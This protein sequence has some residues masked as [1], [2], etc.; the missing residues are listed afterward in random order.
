MIN[1]FVTNISIEKQGFE[2]VNQFNTIEPKI[3]KDEFLKQA[4]TKII[5]NK[6][7]PEDV[8]TAEFEAVKTVYSTYMVVDAHYTGNFSASIG[9]ERV[10]E[11][12]TTEEYYDSKLGMK[13]YRP[14]TKTRTV[15]DWQPF[16]GVI[17]RDQK[18][19]VKLNSDRKV[20]V[21]L[22]L[23]KDLEGLQTC[24]KVIPIEENDELLKHLVAPTREN[25]NDS[26]TLGEKLI[27]NQLDIPGDRYQDFKMNVS[28]KIKSIQ[29]FIIPE[30]ILDYQYG[31]DKCQVG[32]PL[33]DIKVVG[34]VP[35]THEE[36]DNM[37]DSRIK[38]YGITSIIMTSLAILFS[39][40]QL[41]V[42]KKTAFIWLNATLMGF[43]IV[44]YIL[45]NIQSNR[46]ESRIRK[47]S[48]IHKLDNLEIFLAEND[49]PPLTEEEK[50]EADNNARN[51]RA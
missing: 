34:T 4:Y 50:K 40:M 13:R 15:T 35:D 41:M 10:E 8:L 37:I 20:D 24:G 51:W 5:M 12:Q 27:S 7:A 30:Y 22:E 49:L 42:I 43:A 1:N 46:I 9:Y 18:S 11:Y 6:V 32:S 38:P 3:T 17:D 28:H 33:Y 45:F 23:L 16:T 29:Y 21:S 39:L 25:S 26:I 48:C 47:D 44:F 36:L 14:V 19:C 31:E 2:D